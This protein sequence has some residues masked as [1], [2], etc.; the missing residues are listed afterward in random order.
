MENEHSSV[1]NIHIELQSIAS[2]LELAIMPSKF[3]FCPL[4]GNHFLDI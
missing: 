1:T 2:T 3:I 4:K